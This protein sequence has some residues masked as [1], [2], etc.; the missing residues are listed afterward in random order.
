MEKKMTRKKR[1]SEIAADPPGRSAPKAGVGGGASGDRNNDH[2]PLVKNH[3]KNKVWHKAPYGRCTMS[4]F[5][6]DGATIYVYLWWGLTCKWC[7]EGNCQARSGT[8]REKR[9]DAIQA[10]REE[11]ETYKEWLVYKDECSGETS[12]VANRKTTK[13]K[14]TKEKKTAGMQSRVDKMENRLKETDSQMYKLTRENRKLRKTLH[15]K[16]PHPSRRRKQPSDSEEEEEEDSEG[17]P[18]D[19]KESEETEPM[20]R[21]RRSSRRRVAPSRRRG[22]AVRPDA[23]PRRRSPKGAPSA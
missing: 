6:E 22:G 8:P 2:R 12:G 11:D 9:A 18:E 14:G 3:F 5:G 10:M 20:A 17:G 4:P 1:A 7:A 16:S 19:S 15:S 13:K 21:K 23:R